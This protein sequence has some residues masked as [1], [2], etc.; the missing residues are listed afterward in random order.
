MVAVAVVAT[1]VMLEVVDQAVKEVQTIGVVTKMVEAAVELVDTKEMVVEEK[2]ISMVLENTVQQVV[3]E[4]ECM[5]EQ[6]EE[7]V[8]DN[9]DNLD[10]ELV[11]MEH[12]VVNQD[13]L[14]TETAVKLDVEVATVVVEVEE[15]KV[16]KTMVVD[17]QV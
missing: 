13:H 6:V 2:I 14:P 10:G 17:H 8:V 4:Q 9:R 1:V 12:Q 16:I 15:K 11:E 5:V 3:V 7:V